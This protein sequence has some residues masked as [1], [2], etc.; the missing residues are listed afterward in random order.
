[1]P[2]NTAESN[3]GVVF[4]QWNGTSATWCSHGIK[5]RLST[6]LASQTVINSSQFI[7]NSASCGGVIMS[8]QNTVLVSE[9]IFVNNTASSCGGVVYAEDTINVVITGNSS[10]LN[11]SAQNKGGV[12]YVNGTV[13]NVHNS[14]FVS[15]RAGKEGAVLYYNMAK[16]GATIYAV[17]ECKILIIRSQI[18]QNT[19][20]K[21]ALF[22]KEGQL[23]LT[24]VTF[25]YNNG[26]LYAYDSRV[27][28]NG[29]KNNFFK[30]HH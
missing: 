23:N 11:N 14:T 3:A 22:V 6:T 10:F 19:A 8:F 29:L 25:S 30:T 1:M 21:G 12:M 24:D 18:D 9:S 16:S 28:L 2:I 7:N 13:L 5:T 20:S 15:N 4:S 26:S 27:I 17:S